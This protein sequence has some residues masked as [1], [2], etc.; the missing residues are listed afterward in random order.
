MCYGLDVLHSL[1]NV[2]SIIV[3]INV[4]VCC[5]LV[6]PGQATLLHSNFSVI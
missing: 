2:G 4:V 1:T 5:G 3:T 6:H